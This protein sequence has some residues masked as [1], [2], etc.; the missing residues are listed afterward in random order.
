M[1]TPEC[2]G[3]AETML[4]HDLEREKYQLYNGT[5]GYTSRPHLLNLKNM[6]LI[7]MARLVFD[8]GRGTDLER[9][10]AAAGG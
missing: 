2:E 5:V 6:Q 9:N 3:I 4:N 1:P 7:I 8:L 10:H